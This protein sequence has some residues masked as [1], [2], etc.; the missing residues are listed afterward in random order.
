[1]QNTIYPHYKKKFPFFKNVL[2]KSSTLHM[3]RKYQYLAIRQWNVAILL[4]PQ[5]LS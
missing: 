1:M 4:Y 5:S 2:E 3:L